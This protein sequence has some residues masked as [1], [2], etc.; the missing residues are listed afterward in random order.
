[1]AT[2]PGPATDEEDD[3]LGLP[4]LL[5]P[6]QTAALLTRRDS[7]LR[8]RVRAVQSEVLPTGSVPEVSAGQEGWRAAAALRRE[9]NQLVSQVAART[10]APHAKVH[11]QLRTAIPGPVSSAASVDV[12]ER[13]R[14]HLLGM[15]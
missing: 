5:T 2:A 11:V 14:D 12:L 13:R 8:R 10:G 3:F 4:G 15:L 9:V 1:M 6:E 7:E